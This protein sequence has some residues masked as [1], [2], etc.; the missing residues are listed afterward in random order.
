VR[1][2]T[3]GERGGQPRSAERVSIGPFVPIVETPVVAPGPQ[4]VWVEGY[5]RRSG[6]A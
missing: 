5:Y 4:Y 2:V 3:T 1:A 6:G